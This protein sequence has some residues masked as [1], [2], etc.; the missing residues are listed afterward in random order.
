[1]SAAG[2]EVLTRV[3]RQVLA[4][5]SEASVLSRLHGPAHWR[6]VAVAGAR[7]VGLTPGADPLV[8][9]LFALFHDS[10]RRHDGSD[11]GHGSRASRLACKLLEDGDL[12]SAE[13]LETL[14]HAIEGH[15]AGEASEDPTIGACWDADRLNLWRVGIEP[16]PALLS[17]A[18]ARSPGLIEWGRELQGQRY[19]WEDVLQIP[20]EA[21][22]GNLAVLDTSGFTQRKKGKV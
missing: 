20:M 11:R 7:L 1:M 5:S 6:R 9:L 15:D 2:M 10:M 18:A 22:E 3:Q 17:T 16:D 21:G 14:L 12:V 19:S 13:Q 8:V 4:C